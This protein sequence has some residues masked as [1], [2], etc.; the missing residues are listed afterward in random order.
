VFRPGDVEEA[1]AREQIVAEVQIS[2]RPSDAGVSQRGD[3]ADGVRQRGD[4]CSDMLGVLVLWRALH[5]R[6]HTYVREEGHVT[7]ATLSILLSLRYSSL[8]DQAT[9]ESA[10]A[11]TRQTGCG[12]AGMRAL[13]P[14]RSAPTHVAPQ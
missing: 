4:A 12:S 10:S 5:A 13:A 1:V 6:G 3:K 7:P 11:A 8:R 14:A 9:G 2:A